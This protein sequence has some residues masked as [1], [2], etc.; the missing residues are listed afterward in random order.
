ML[1]VNSA[2][3]SFFATAMIL[4][5]LSMVPG[6]VYGA[7]VD[8]VQ[9]AL[10]WK[11]EPEFGGFYAAQIEGHYKTKGLDVKILPG[12]AGTPVVQMVANGQVDFGIVSADEALMSRARGSD[13]VAIFTV[14][15]KNPQ[16]IMVHADR[17]FSSIADV[18]KHEG[19]LALQQGLP[20]VL[21]FAK[22][23]GN[24]KVKMVPYSG[25]VANFLRDKSFA[26]QCYIF[27][28]PLVAEQ[29]GVK[30]Q[31]F[32]IADE[33]YNPYAT[34]VV[35]RRSYYE[36]NPDLTKRFVEAIRMGWRGYL[37]QPA[38][39]NKVMS[40]LNKSMDPSIFAKGAEAQKSLI[41]TPE[42]IKN[43]LGKMTE[44]RWKQLSEQLVDLKLIQRPQDPSDVYI[45]L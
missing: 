30:P 10:N 13:V 4:V 8:K 1:K 15:Q 2:H 24:P 25:G 45:D 38:A 21:Y 7:A 14:Y 20:Y 32:L 11:P 31:V 33:G 41:E 37:D 19:T 39:A 18:Y 6:F 9:L 3:R 28:E 27:S 34:L 12:G 35:T 17:K 5:I 36:K 22:K 42:T 40:D 23:Y 16:G 26:Q 29:N 43:G 44:Q